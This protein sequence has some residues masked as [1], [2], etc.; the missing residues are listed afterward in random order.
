MNRHMPIVHGSEATTFFISVQGEQDHEVA[1]A[2]LVV[3]QEGSY[4]YSSYVNNASKLAVY[5][6]DYVFAEAIIALAQRIPRIYLTKTS[7]GYE[8]LKN[9]GQRQDDLVVIHRPAP[10]FTGQYFD[11]GTVDREGNLTLTLAHSLLLTAQDVVAPDGST[12][13]LGPAVSSPSKEATKGG[14]DLGARHLRLRT[15]GR[16]A[17]TLPR[18]DYG[19]LRDVMVDGIAPNIFA[20]VPVTEPSALFSGSLN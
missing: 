8:Y 19:N 6:L 9:I 10:I 11:T 12:V 20:V 13:T 16:D 18:R 4:V 14:I 7:A 5:D 17:V 15:S 3:G 2:I 1:V